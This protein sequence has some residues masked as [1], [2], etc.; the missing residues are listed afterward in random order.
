MR[1]HTPL[2]DE[3]TLHL[4]GV[5][6]DEAD[7]CIVVRVRSSADCCRCPGCE[8]PAKRV[9]SRYERHLADLP[10]QGLRVR[11]IWSTRRF[12]CDVHECSRKIFAERQP[13]VAA[14]HARRTARLSLVIRCIGLACGGETGSR[15]AE[16]LGIRVSADSLLHE[17]RQ[18]SPPVPTLP[19]AVGIDDWAFRKGLRYGTVICDLETGRAIDLLDDRDADSVADWLRRHETIEVISRDRGDV[20]RKGAAVGAPKAVQVADRFHLIKNLRDAFGRFLE[21]Q[22]H[23]IRDAVRQAES[24]APPLEDLPEVMSANTTRADRRKAEN[25]SRRQELYDQIVQLRKEG[26]SA[27]SIAVRLGVHRSTVQKNLHAGGPGER[28]LRNY[29][30]T[31]DRF[32]GYLWDRWQ[33]GCCNASLLYGEIVS[34]GYEGSYPSVR[35]IVGR[36]RRTHPPNFKA[37][38]LP[39]PTPSPTQVSWLLFKIPSKLSSKELALK[40]AILTHCEDIRAAWQAARRFVVILRARKGHRLKSWVKKATQPQIPPPIRQFANGLKQDWD[41]IVAGLTLHWN[42]AVAEGHVNRLKLI[43]RQMY[44]RANFDLLRAR[45]LAAA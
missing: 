42:N 19:R 9:H 17:V 15:L 22:T 35:R 41:A 21:G 36:W 4:E 20:Y 25:Q 33:A 16:R 37:K 28:D 32:K 26:E 40:Q 5:E 44:G 24:I 6:H 13:A 23:A 12:F 10:W 38:P 30:S 34:R 29:A 39:Q 8:R 14:P 18:E 31:A 43:K 11:L 1:V 2:P 45:F 3:T 7:A 27:R